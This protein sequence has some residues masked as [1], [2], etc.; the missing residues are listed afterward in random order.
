MPRAPHSAASRL[1]RVLSTVGPLPARRLVDALG[2]RANL[3]FVT[4]HELHAAGL[5]QRVPALPRQR[6]RRTAAA[7]VLSGSGHL[8]ADAEAVAE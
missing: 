2:V 6:V 4:L 5:V 1:L 7:Y 3:V 8:G